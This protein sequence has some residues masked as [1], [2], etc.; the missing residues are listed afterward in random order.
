MID[1]NKV[2]D[3]V[4]RLLAQEGYQNIKRLTTMQQGIDIEAEHPQRGRICIEAK[5]G[6]STKPDSKRYGQPFNSNQVYDVVAKGAYA[7][8]RLHSKI[9]SNNYQTALA[10][11]DYPIFREHSK[12]IAAPFQALG[13]RLILVAE[14]GSAQ[15]FL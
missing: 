9:A 12:A 7:V 4:C 11:P 8:F 2:I 5:G 10:L 1:E 3:G 6:T 15:Y 13:L 14:D